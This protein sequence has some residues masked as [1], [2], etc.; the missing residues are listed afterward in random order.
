MDII[1]PRVCG[2][3]VHKE[4]VVACVRM[5]GP[6]G[7]ISKETR[8]FGTMTD[9]LLALKGWLQRS[10]VTQIAME[11]TGVYWKPVW[12]ILDGAF[13][14]LLVN[15]QHIK[16]VPG[17][18]TDVKDAEWIA[19]ILQHGLLRGSFVPDRE[20]R[21]LR[22]LMRSRTTLLDA[23]SAVANRLQ[24]VLEDANIKLASVA[25][26]VLG[27]SG[28]AML[29][30]IIAGEDSPEVLA[31]LAKG[32]LREKR[33]LLSR[34]LQGQVTE[35]HRFMLKTYMEQ[36]EFYDAQ[37]AKLDERIVEATSS[38]EAAIELAD[39]VPGIDRRGAENILAEIG[40]DME[41]FPNADHLSSWA[42]ISPGNNE[43]AGKRKSGKTSSGNKWLRRA[44][45]EAGW[46]AV[47]KK[48]CYFKSQYKKLLGRRGKKR[49][50]VAV[51]HSILVTL[52]YILR[53]GKSYEE[54]GEDHFD[55]L[56]P[57]RAT[58]YHKRKLEK[59]GYKVTLE[60]LPTAA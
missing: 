39:T 9:E 44:L 7:K 58:N 42:G 31:G 52:Y 36:V 27:A 23:R 19:E 21:E 15:A 59:L 30:A 33:G 49:A 53:R 37:V 55:K 4:T 24:K 50:I 6:K 60:E 38:L 48:G 35:H 13:E 2:L 34:A 20:L 22:D 32:Q 1:F 47:R 51:G 8:T 16:Q 46:A 43:S 54:L 14:L 26:D 5:V 57:E 3:D 41:Q 12:N 45:V 56:D 17:R 11:S 18:K 25:T 28:R 10:E 29:W 40:A